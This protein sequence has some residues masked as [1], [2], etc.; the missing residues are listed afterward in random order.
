MKRTVLASIGL[1][2]AAVAFIVA[3]G[4]LAQACGST[5]TPG[6]RARLAQLEADP[7]LKFRAPGTKLLDQ[8]QQSSARLWAFEE[9]ETRVDQVLSMSGDPAATVD[10]Y[11]SVAEANGWGLAF[12]GCSRA[13][14]ATG[15]AFTRVVD[16]Q[17]VTLSVRAEL[18]SSPSSSRRKPTLTV[19]MVAGG[20]TA[21]VWVGTRRNDLRCL[22]GLDPSSPEIVRPEIDH[23][24]PEA[25]CAAVDL[26][27]IQGV[28][29]RIPFSPLGDDYP[30]AC[31]FDGGLNVGY[32]LEVEEASEPLAHYQDHSSVDAAPGQP[33]A[34]EDYEAG[35]WLLSPHGPLV[36]RS[37][38]STSGEYG[39]SPERLLRIARDLAT[40]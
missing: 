34:F 3:Y 28:K 26:D 40:L 6:A 14:Q 17:S 16:N 4:L 5:P 19:S 11:S 27:G 25:L 2:T 20:D 12:E 24:T 39:M 9:T 37:R 33:F 32:V 7:V 38:Y 31:H 35:V 18:G 36:V 13:H 21:V 29:E 1:A 22:V 23:I 30:S 10:A 8:S 15:R